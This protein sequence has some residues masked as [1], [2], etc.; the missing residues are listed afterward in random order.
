MASPTTCAHLIK[1]RLVV[2]TTLVRSE[3][4]ESKSPIGLFQSLARAVVHFPIARKVLTRLR[5]A[6][7]PN[8]ASFITLKPE[9]FFHRVPNMATDKSDLI[10]NCFTGSGTTAVFSHKIHRRWIGIETGEHTATNCLP[11][12]QKVIDSE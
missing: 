11:R 9:R 6:P 5:D 7:F 12:L 8:Y 4:L 1:P 10:L 3:S 2:I